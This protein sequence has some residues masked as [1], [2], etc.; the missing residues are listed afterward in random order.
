MSIFLP[1]LFAIA[2]LLAPASIMMSLRRYGSAALAIAGE[3][4]RPEAMR[5]IRHRT[6]EYRLANAP[7]NVLRP[8]FGVRPR[9]HRREREARL[10]AAA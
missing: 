3:L 1:L 4:R 6:F 7:A 2:G 5:E 10:L 9:S 8:D